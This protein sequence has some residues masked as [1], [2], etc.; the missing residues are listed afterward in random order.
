MINRSAEDALVHESSSHLSI[1]ERSLDSKSE[2]LPF[3][4]MHSTTWLD[5]LLMVMDISWYP[6]S[7]YMLITECFTSTKVCCRWS[8][9][10]HCSNHCCWSQADRPHNIYP[11]WLNHFVGCCYLFISPDLLFVYQQL[12]IVMRLNRSDLFVRSLIRILPILIDRHIVGRTCELCYR[13]LTWSYGSW[14]LCWTVLLL[15]GIAG[16]LDVAMGLFLLGTIWC[17]ARVWTMNSVEVIVLCFGGSL[18]QP[19]TVTG[20]GGCW[21]EVVAFSVADLCSL[22]ISSLSVLVFCVSTR[23]IG[24]KRSHCPDLLIDSCL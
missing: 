2:I 18:Y 23:R 24:W 11:C 1:Q 22:P 15:F 16:Y 7:Y 8:S 19:F 21:V 9:V 5:T 10:L 4:V 17:I 13:F 12:V 3:V 14:P 20:H 6:T